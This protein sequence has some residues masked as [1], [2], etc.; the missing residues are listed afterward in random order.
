M[1]SNLIY[2]GDNLETLAK[3]PEK[4]VGLIYADPPFFSNKK[5]EIIWDNG[6]EM[7]VYED[8]WKG[9]INVYIE[10]MKE[11]LWQCHRVLKD[12]GSMYLHCDWHATHRLRLAMDDV[13]DEKNFQNEIIWHYRRW[14]NV[15]ER[16]QRMHDTI[17]FYTK[18][19]NYKFNPT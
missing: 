6:A 19:E 5:Y 4:S 9:G 11:R 3:F 1:E 7:K 13:F 2:C 8:R 14:T 16:F 12:T 18:T 17:L 15:S 10:W